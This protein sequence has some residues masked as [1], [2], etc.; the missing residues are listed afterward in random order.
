MQGLWMN[1]DLLGQ[2][3]KAAYCRNDVPEKNQRRLLVSF[4]ELANSILKKTFC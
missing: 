1:V 3:G 4:K 2:D